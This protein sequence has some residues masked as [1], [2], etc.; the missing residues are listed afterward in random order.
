MKKYFWNL[1]IVFA[2]FIACVVKMVELVFRG[3]AWVFGSC[4]DLLDNFNAWLGFD[5]TKTKEESVEELIG[6]EELDL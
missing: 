5:P 3:I 2:G 4:A 1:V 6:V